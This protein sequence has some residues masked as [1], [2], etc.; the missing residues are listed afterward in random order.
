MAEMKSIKL[1]QALKEMTYGEPFNI[2]FY[3]ADFKRKT[4]GAIVELKDV[5]LTWDKSKDHKYKDEVSSANT[6]SHYQHATRNF[7]M[8]NGKIR[9][10]HIWLMREF[11]NK[12]IVL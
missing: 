8:N 7:L 5:I 2:S 3:T 12:R 6:P 4:G 1:K 11:N 9:K 10:A